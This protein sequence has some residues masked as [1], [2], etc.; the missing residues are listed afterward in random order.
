MGRLE[1]LTAWALVGWLIPRCGTRKL[2]VLQGRTAYE[3][4]TLDAQDLQNGHGKT[5]L[6]D[7]HGHPRN[8][9]TRRRERE[10]VRAA[11]EV[12]QVTGV[13][14]DSITA[15]ARARAFRVDKNEETL[16][17]L[18]LMEVGRSVLVAGVWGTMGLRKRILLYRS[19]S[20][21]GLLGILRH[22]RALHSDAHLILTG[23]PA[24]AAFNIVDWASF[25]VQIFI[26]VLGDEMLISKKQQQVAERWSVCRLFSGVIG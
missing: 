6:Y 13:V 3:D 22:E 16:T 7:E 2:T 23:L 26:S 24:V 21:T 20:Q 14:E 4:E 9:E 19:Y 12:M 17:G 10:L 5:Q 15:K 11:N 18:N 8:P 25:P 1:S